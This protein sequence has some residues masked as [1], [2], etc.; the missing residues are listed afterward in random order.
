M[1]EQEKKDL[2]P[3]L[4]RTEQEERLR[5]EVVP[6]KREVPW[7]KLEIR[8]EGALVGEFAEQAQLE[9]E[10]KQ[11]LDQLFKNEIDKMRIDFAKE[12]FEEHL[13]EIEDRGYE[14][15]GKEA[16]YRVRVAYE[17]GAFKELK[18]KAEYQEISE[19]LDNLYA[20]RTDLKKAKVPLETQ[21]LMLNFLSKKA[22]ILEKERLRAEKKGDLTKMIATEHQLEELFKLREDL[23]SKISGRD[24]RK[25]AENKVEP[26]Q[27]KEDYINSNLSEKIKE[28]KDPLQELGYKKEEKGMLWW[29]RTEVFDQQGERLGKFKKKQELDEFLKGKLEEKV[30]EVL[31]QEWEEKSKTREAEIKRLIEK[32]IIPL[33]QSPEKAVEGVEGVYKRVRERLITEFVEKDLKKQ[34]KTR[35]ELERIEKVFSGEE[36]KAGEFIDNVLHRKGVLENLQ[37]DWEKDQEV[38]S[39]FLFNWGIEVSSKRLDQYQ[40]IMAQKGKN[41]ERAIRKKRGFLEWFLEM[42]VLLFER[43]YPKETKKER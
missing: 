21:F 8:E 15:Q 41:Y 30:K 42:I 40:K 25:E 17:L 2:Q 1:L 43:P 33:A 23:A 29:K 7:E 26:L 24:L 39:E 28:V 35:Q 22:E 6:E 10:T 34:E 31:S 12:W 27:E 3:E 36:R 18:E 4:D 9:P 14:V 16:G 20:L 19:V 32:E 5:Q 37:G 13:D 11:G 38:L